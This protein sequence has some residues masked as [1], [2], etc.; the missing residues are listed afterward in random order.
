MAVFFTVYTAVFLV[1]NDRSIAATVNGWISGSLRG[2]GGPTSQAMVMG[3]A[4][5]Y[6]GALKTLFFGGATWVEVWDTHIYDPDGNEVMNIPYVRTRMYL[7]ETVWSQLFSIV[8]EPD[9]ELHFAD[10]EVPAGVCHIAL[11]RAGGV[12]LVDAFAPRWPAPSPGG[13]RIRV[14]GMAI[15]DAEFSMAMPGWHAEVHHLATSGHLY[16]STFADETEPGKPMFTYAVNPLSAP[17]ATL[18]LGES[19]PVGARAGPTR[20]VTSPPPF[21]FPIEQLVSTRFGAFA[22]RREDLVFHATARSLGAP[23]TVDGRILNCYGKAAGVD[24]GIVFEHGAGLLKLLPTGDLVGGDPAGD[25]RI[26]GPFSDVRIDGR[27][28]GA[29]VRLAGL[30]GRHARSRFAVHGSVLR[31]TESRAEI[32]GGAVGGDLELDFSRGTWKGDFSSVRPDRIDPSGLALLPA[33]VRKLLAGQL[34]GGAHL[35]GSFVDHPERIAVRKIDLHLDRRVERDDLLPRSLDLR[36]ALRY[37]P[38]RLRLDGV[39]VTGDGISASARGDLDPIHATAAADLIVDARNP[40]ALLRRLGVR[41]V[42]VSALHLSAHVSG[43]LAEP[44]AEGEVD[45]EVGYLGRTLPGAHAR[46]KFEHGTLAVDELRARGPLGGL[47]TG[48]LRLDLFNG[49]FD[50]PRVEQPLALHLASTGI[51]IPALTGSP[52]ITGMVTGQLHLGGTLQHITGGADVEVPTMKIFADPYKSGILSVDF[53]DGGVAVKKLFLQREGGGY[54]DQQKGKQGTIGKDGSLDL[55]VVS[56]DFPLSSIPQLRDFPVALA[57]TLSGAAHIAGNLHRWIPSGVIEAAAIRVRE[58][59]LGDGR[60][61]L[62]PSGDGIHLVGEFFD[63][64]KID[65]HLTLYPRIAC[66]LT[67]TFADFP[68]EQL[69]PELKKVAELHGIVSGQASFSFDATEG[70]T[71]AELR[72]DKVLLTLVGDDEGDD[73]TARQTDEFRNQ[74]DEPV[75]ITSDGKKLTFKQ[76]HLRS[77]IGEFEVKGDLSATASRL[78]VR[79]QI[80]VRL[81]EYFFSSVFAHIHGEANADLLITGAAARPEVTGSL[82]L[83]NAELEPHG[84]ERP[85]T[86][87]SGRVVFEKD[88]VTLSHLRA[89]LDGAEAEANGSLEFKDWVPGLL[90]LSINGTLSPTLL[91]WIFPENIGE[92]KG[93]LKVAATMNGRWPQPT[94]SGNI[95]VTDLDFHEKRLGRD[96]HIPAGT[97]FLDNYDLTLGCPKRDAPAGCRQL[98]AR[99]DDTGDVR[100]DGRI[101]LPGFELGRVDVHL[102]GDNLE[103]GTSNYSLTLSPRI[104]LKGDG[105]QLRLAGDISIITGRYQQDFDYRGLLF[106]PRVTESDEPFYRGIP[107]LEGLELALHASS[108]GPLSINSNIAHL[109]VTVSR[110]GIGG[111]LDEPRFDGMILVEEDGTFNIPFLRTEFRTDR[112]STITFQGNREFPKQTPTLSISASSDFVDR[113]ENIHRIEL[114]VKGTYLEPDIDLRSQDGWDKA[115]VLEALATGAT[116]DEFRHSLQGDPGAH[117]GGSA[118]PLIKELSGQVLG[119]LVE[120]PLKKVFRLDTVKIELGTDS[121]HVKLCL[122]SSRQ[123]KLCGLGDVSFTTTAR[124]SAYSELKLTDELSLV[125]SVEHIEHGLDTTEDILTRGR[126]QLQLKLPLH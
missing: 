23:L 37:A 117:T 70:L 10:A 103:W 89:Q 3:R 9:L 41:D 44:L 78:L 18:T 59:L 50:H 82:E 21:V 119:N 20:I 106:K 46:L 53:K 92:A 73:V 125:G 62:A 64:F 72:L 102:D 17:T 43:P 110:L 109:T 19:I 54:I 42:N 7:G 25:V 38:E 85:F 49:R 60:L 107:L 39:S 123:I 121:L 84:A 67:V 90:A 104:D 101:G 86:V 118:D 100:I 24:L 65:G 93:T 29:E 98:S 1:W 108:S 34:G 77:R 14:D 2:R 111:T 13:M 11:D 35:E 33:P 30:V 116:S 124:Y 57:G 40:D 122:Y 83:S 22:E 12:N 88:R 66:N 36:G 63:R 45:A 5:P 80:D 126:L 58:V 27:A 76:A 6:W 99:I 52:T 74:K 79:G 69:I 47:L 26:H 31:L 75:I 115:K 112:N 96:I 71:A 114:T 16:A 91:T 15:G 113:L 87:P 28:E 105:H 81:L 94:W 51:A 32:A 56:K 8:L 4:N 55:D 61:D 95:V 48:D 97:I 68:L 120:D